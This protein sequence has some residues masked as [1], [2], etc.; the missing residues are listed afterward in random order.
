MN[1]RKQYFAV[2]YPASKAA[3]FG[4]GKGTT[5]DAAKQA[6]EDEA[7][8]L[9]DGEELNGKTYECTEELFSKV[10]KGLCD[11]PVLIDDGVARSK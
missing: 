2:Y 1:A 9:G 4:I 7:H 3:A 6:A 10:K 5:L 11:T 8:R